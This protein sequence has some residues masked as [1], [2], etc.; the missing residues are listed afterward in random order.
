MCAMC[1]VS[2]WR[3]CKVLVTY[4]SQDTEHRTREEED[5]RRGVGEWIR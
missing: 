5:G 2:P 4:G 3:S 1:T